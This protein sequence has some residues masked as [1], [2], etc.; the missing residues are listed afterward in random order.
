MVSREAMAGLG[1]QQANDLA[2]NAFNGSVYGAAFIALLCIYPGN[3]NISTGGST[4]VLSNV[5]DMLAG[6][7][8]PDSSTESS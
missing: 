1:D 5:D 6:V 3:A 8:G 2:G 4:G 7:I